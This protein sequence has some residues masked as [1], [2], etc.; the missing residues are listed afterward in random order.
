MFNTATTA[1][2]RAVHEDVCQELSC[3]QTRTKSHVALRILQA[4]SEGVVSVDDL[5]QVGKMALR[6]SDAERT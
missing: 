3:Y 1:L 5:R 6:E 2:L 4:A